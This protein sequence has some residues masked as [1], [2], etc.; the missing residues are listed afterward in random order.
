MLL[1]AG[2]FGAVVR[3]ISRNVACV[4]ISERLTDR[5]TDWQAG[6]QADSV[7]PAQVKPVQH[8]M[9]APV[10]AHRFLTFLCFKLPELLCAKHP[11]RLYVY[12]GGIVLPPPPLDLSKYA[13]T[14]THRP[15]FWPGAQ[16]GSRRLHSAESSLRKTTKK[17]HP[18]SQKDCTKGI[19]SEET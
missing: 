19:I 3:G 16:A 13:R 4:C 18:P 1:Q 6:R 8:P 12:T 2:T 17:K 14:V 9:C 7:S 10:F 5:Q 15:P 11:P